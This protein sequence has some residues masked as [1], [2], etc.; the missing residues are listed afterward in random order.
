[1]ALRVA[2]SFLTIGIFVCGTLAMAQPTPRSA[3]LPQARVTLGDSAVPLYGPWKFTVGDA[4]IDPKTGKPLWAEPDSDD[5]RWETVD[6]TPKDGAFDPLVGYSGYVPG[7]TG[8]GH[9]GY[10]GYAWYRIRVQLETRPGQTLSLS[11]PADVDDAY[12]VFDNGMLAGQFGDFAGNEPIVFAARPKMFPLPQAASHGVG[13][14]PD[15]STQVLAF[16]FWSSLENARFPSGSIDRWAPMAQN[17]RC[18]GLQQT[19]H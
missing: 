14:V 16:R 2:L 13:V 3:S 4:P 10:W 11:G 17:F 7:W 5:S 6:L 12:Q 8:K 1:M 19:F 9:P 18:R 15:K